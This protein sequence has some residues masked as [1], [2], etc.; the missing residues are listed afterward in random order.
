MFYRRCGEP[1]HSSRFDRPEKSG[2]DRV[3]AGCS[4]RMRMKIYINEDFCSGCGICIE[5]CPRKVL[6]SSSSLSKK[7]V[8]PPVVNRIEECTGC[9]MCELY[10]PDFAIAVEENKDE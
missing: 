4:G 6:D 7:G 1:L 10:C 5:F 9:N 3:G 2:Y 8:F